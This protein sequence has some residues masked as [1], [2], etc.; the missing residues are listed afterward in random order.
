MEHALENPDNL[1]KKAL[2]EAGAFLYSFKL[3][4]LENTTI[5]MQKLMA[6][7]PRIPLRRYGGNV[8]EI[9][10]AALTVALEYANQ[11]AKDYLQK[12]LAMDFLATLKKLLEMLEKLTFLHNNNLI[13][14]AGIRGRITTMLPRYEFHELNKS[15]LE[16]E[17]SKD[18]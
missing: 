14:T 13:K 8:V 9:T 15:L 7:R 3:R 10:P 2:A 16:K 11:I 12:K 1:Q 5:A 18:K 17:E 4:M 6:L